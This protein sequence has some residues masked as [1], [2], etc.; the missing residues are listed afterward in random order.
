M[1][2]EA[3]LD[4]ELS[5]QGLMNLVGAWREFNLSPYDIEL[6]DLVRCPALA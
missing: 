4:V 2:N 3:Q 5:I 6:S 1:T